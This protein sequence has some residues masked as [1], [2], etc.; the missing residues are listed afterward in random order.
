LTEQRKLAAVMFTDIAGYTALMSRDEQKALSLLEKN[1]KLQKSL[2]KKHYG[3]FLKEMGDGTL[4][5]FQSALDAVRCAMEI[6]ESVKDDPV[7][8][9]RIGIHSGDVVFKKGDIFGDGVNVASR[10][11]KMAEAGGICL[12]EEVYKSV[13][14]QADVQALFLAET[15]LKHVDGPVKIYRIG[16]ADEIAAKAY[17]QSTSLTA[18]EKSIIVLPFVNISPDP[19][20]E[21]FSDGLTEEVITNLSCIHDLL[22]ISRNSAMTYKGTKKKTGEI[23]GEANVRYVLEGSVRK[24]GKNLRITA[25]LIRAEDDAHIWADTYSGLLDDVF[26]IQERVSRSIAEAL[27]IQ[28]TPE[29]NDEIDAHPLTNMKAYDCYLRAKQEFVHFTEESLESAIALLADGLEAVGDN[30]LLYSLLGQINW[31]FVNLGIKLDN[32]YL[33]RAEDCVSRIFALDQ[34]SAHGYYL[35]GLIDYKRGDTQSSVK[36]TKLALEKDPHHSDAIDHL[37]WMYADAGRTERSGPYI[38]RILEIDPF[39]PHNHWVIG[40]TRVTQGDFSAGLPYFE[41]THAMDPENPIW[42]LLYAHQL[43]LHGKTKKGDAVVNTMDRETPGE[44]LTSMA[45]LFKYGCLGKKKEALS[46][47]TDEILLFGE[48]DELISWMLA[49]AYALVNEK[50]HALQWL[51]HAADRGFINYPF[52]NQIDPFLENIRGEEQF[53]KLMQRI[54]EKWEHFEV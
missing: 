45:L 4:L 28:L 8:K 54:K 38:K 15:K 41:K 13:R 51:Q 30:V 22:V 19:D 16:E 29:E 42:R 1:R 44:M 24:A 35:L 12:S 5:C 11:E 17:R 21:Y 32:R 46:H 2:A 3:E 43:Y 18:S 27:K 10:I 37:L 20:Q 49:Q 25:Q 50:Q 47:I 39:T 34:A 48:W 52:F 14:N 9:L 23:A 40:W 53:G 36:H 7:L 31:A 33:D 6:Q 26:A